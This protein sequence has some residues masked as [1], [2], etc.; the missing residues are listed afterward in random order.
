MSLSHLAYFT[1]S[2]HIML[3]IDCLF[4]LA[5]YLIKEDY[6][7]NP[8]VIRYSLISSFLFFFSIN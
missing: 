3:F 1:I 2:K 5:P 8:F 7:L 4:S 6:Q